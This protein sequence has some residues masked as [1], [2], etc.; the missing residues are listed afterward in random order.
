[1][2]IGSEGPKTRSTW[3]VRADLK[4][5]HTMRHRRCS[6]C[7]K[8]P[9]IKARATVTHCICHWYDRA[10]YCHLYDFFSWPGLVAFIQIPTATRT[11]SCKCMNECMMIPPTRLGSRIICIALFTVTN[12][13]YNRLPK[14][15]IFMPLTHILGYEICSAASSQTHPVGRLSPIKT[16]CRIT[17]ATRQI[18]HFRHCVL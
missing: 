13:Q 5:T 7:W 16:I 15:R 1:M 11:I 14:K 12:Q 3:Q 18:F 9:Q 17:H 10:G 4:G 2:R 8:Y 6:G